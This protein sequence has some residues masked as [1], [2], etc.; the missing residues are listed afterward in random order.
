MSVRKR[1]SLSRSAS[2]AAL[3]SVKST[4]KVTIWFP[5]SSTVAEPSMIG[6]RLPSFRKY[7][8]SIGGRRPVDLCSR[9]HRASR[10][11]QSGGVRSVQR[12]RPAW[13]SSRSYPTM[14]RKASLASRIR[15]SKSAMK[16]PTMLASTRRRIFAF[17]SCKI[18]VKPGILQRDRRLRGKQLQHRDPGGRE[19]VGA[20]LFSRYSTPM[21]LAWL[22]SGRQRIERGCAFAEVG[23]AEKRI[24]SGDVVENH[25]LLGAQDIVE[26][27]TPATR[28][29]SRSRRAAAR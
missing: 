13:R 4:T 7:S 23:S 6:T 5:P 18:A 17:R 21:S 2:S 1:S 9:I 16:I 24:L 11:R 22:I 28:P 3:R 25:A 19:D 8:F 27:P 14:R 26:R 29:R 12:S 10:S 20:R 15:P